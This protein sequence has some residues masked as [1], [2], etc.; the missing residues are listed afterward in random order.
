[1]I[2]VAWSEP[3][4]DKLKG[5]ATLMDFARN[6]LA[7]PSFQPSLEVFQQAGEHSGVTLYREGRYQAQLWLCPPDSEITDHAHPNARSIFGLLGGKVRFRRGGFHVGRSDTELL[8]LGRAG[9]L[10]HQVEPGVSHGATIK[11]GGAAFF[12][13]TEWLDDNPRSVHLDW[14]GEPL[15]HKHAEQIDTGKCS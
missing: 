13:I 8:W 1:M 4:F 10:L 9:M 15:D 3:E 7:H 2:H 12:S 11:G 5:S 6:W 14:D